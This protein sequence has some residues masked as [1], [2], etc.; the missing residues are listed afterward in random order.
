MVNRWKSRIAAHLSIGSL[1]RP[2]FEATTG[3]ID[4][5]AQ[6]AAAAEAGFSGVCDN[7]LLIRPTID[8]RRI[9]RALADTG[10]ELGSMSLSPLGGFQLNLTDSDADVDGALGVCLDVIELLNGEGALFGSV[11]AMIHEGDGTREKQ[12]SRVARNLDRGVRFAEANGIRIG[13]EAVSRQ[14]MPTS[15]LERVSDVAPL[16][17]RIGSSSLGL[18]LDSAHAWFAGDDLVEQVIRYAPSLM[19]IQLADM[20][21][22]VEPGGGT[23]DFSGLQGALDS[24]GWTGLVEAELFASQPGAEGEAAVLTALDVV[25]GSLGDTEHAG[26]TAV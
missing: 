18:V 9:G 6:I 26:R 17:D 21:G 4:P 23:L 1:D 16:V 8:Q 19:S 2:P 3:S 7:Q 25:F 14:R 5:V 10:L 22:R 24:I 11:T 12:L 13:L 20:P 15:L